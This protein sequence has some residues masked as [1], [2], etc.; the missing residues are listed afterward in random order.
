M[1]LKEAIKLAKVYGVNPT[2]H[3]NAVVTETGNVYLSD[4]V[5]PKETGERFYFNQVEKP[6]VEEEKVTE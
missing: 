4:N 5:D 2:E 6:K 3:P 1:T